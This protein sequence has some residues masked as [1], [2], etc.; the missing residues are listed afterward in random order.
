[1]IKKYLKVI[2]INLVIFV[3]IFELVSMIYIKYTNYDVPGYKYIPT[4]LDIIIGENETFEN[5]I[6]QDS[7]IIT[8]SNNP[9]SPR[10]IDTLYTWCT[11]HPKNTINRLTD[12]CFDVYLKFNEMGTRGALP[13]SDNLNTILFVGDSFVEGYG[14]EEDSTISERIRRRLNRQ[15]LN[16]GCSG[17]FGSTQMSLVY[18]EFAKQFKH[19]DVYVLLYLNNDFEDNNINNNSA[20]Y[21]KRYRPYRILTKDGSSKIVY[22]GSIDST[23]YSWEFFNEAKRNKF[24][25]KELRFRPNDNFITKLIKLTYSRKVLYFLDLNLIRKGGVPNELIYSI[26]DWKILEFDIESIIESASKQNARVTFINLP[27]RHLL[28]YTSKSIKNAEN[29]I[30]LEAK[31]TNFINKRNGM[32]LSFYNYIKEKN[33]K[34]DLMFFSCDQHYSNY[35]ESV[36]SDFIITNYKK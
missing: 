13:D 4:Y 27:S 29:Y 2:L 25:T 36:L 17:Y 20:A 12:S 22:K 34:T 11:W 8:N 33:V 9:L 24:S 16:L 14:L 1:M 23:V 26:S 10:V 15:V 32:Y 19:K 18:A 7:F 5:V 30:K 28:D 31:L 21:Q 6:M 35:G 3:F